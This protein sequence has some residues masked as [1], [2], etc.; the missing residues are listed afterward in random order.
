MAP[1]TTATATVSMMSAHIN[2]LKTPKSRCRSGE[3]GEVE[4]ITDG[5]EFRPHA[6]ERALSILVIQSSAVTAGSN[7]MPSILR[8]KGN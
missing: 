1:Y 2:P 4:V 3:S 7:A 6:G 5:G 8:T